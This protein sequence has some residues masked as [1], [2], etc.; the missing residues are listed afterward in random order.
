[1]TEA[2][3]KIRYRIEER[4]QE[5]DKSLMKAFLVIE[6]D[7]CTEGCCRLSLWSKP[8]SGI[9][10]NWDGNREAPTVVP[11]INCNNCSR[12]FSIIKGAI[13]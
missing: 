1:M 4:P 10:W 9:M 2:P 8:Q 5:P 7:K 6:C 3:V 13:V 11:S 12:H